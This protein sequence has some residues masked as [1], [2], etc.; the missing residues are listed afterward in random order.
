MAEL[1]LLEPFLFVCVCV[2]ERERTM[3]IHVSIHPQIIGAEGFKLNPVDVPM[4]R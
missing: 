4:V 3:G 1:L 2:R